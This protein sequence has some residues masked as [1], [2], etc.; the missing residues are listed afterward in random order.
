MTV[1]EPQRLLTGRMST[2][3]PGGLPLGSAWTEG[4]EKALVPAKNSVDE[5]GYHHRRQLVVR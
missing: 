4:C 5:A 2:I 1:F 3:R